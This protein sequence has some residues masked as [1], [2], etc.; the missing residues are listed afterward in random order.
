MKSIEIVKY[1]DKYR[2]ETVE[3]IRNSCKKYGISSNNLKDLD[4]IGMYYRDNGSMMLIAYDRTIMRV[5]GTVGFHI[6][7]ETGYIKRCYVDEMYQN[8]GI[9]SKL[10]D[11]ML[12]YIIKST[13][14]RSLKLTTLKR[15]ECAVRY[16]K[17]KGFIIAG[18]TQS[19]IAYELDYNIV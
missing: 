10:W 1:S 12:N 18:D 14:I 3:F 17:S 2:L 16:W 6:D 7:G 19:G 9:G 13:E 15:N 5:V 11:S 8:K 4:N